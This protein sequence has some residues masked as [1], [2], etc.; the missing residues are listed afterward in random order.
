MTDATEE[1]M[2]EISTVSST[3][4]SRHRKFVHIDLKIGL[5]CIVAFVCFFCHV[6]ADFHGILVSSGVRE[7]QCQPV[8]SGD[9]VILGHSFLF[10]LPDIGNQSQNCRNNRRILRQKKKRKEKW[11]GRLNGW[12][13]AS[14]EVGVYLPL[15]ICTTK[16]LQDK[17]DKA[18]QKKQ[19]HWNPCKAAAWN[20]KVGYPVRRKRPEL[21]RSH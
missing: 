18:Q 17:A 1:H 20:R 21:A 9:T 7:C 15:C 10:I 12:S 19:N 4:E 3:R 16:D 5:S 8:R 2:A 11:Y 13:M 6:S 14:G